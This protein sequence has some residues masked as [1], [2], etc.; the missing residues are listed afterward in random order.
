VITLLNIGL[1]AAGPECQIC[2][3]AILLACGNMGNCGMELIFR[4]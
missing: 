2:L 1:A 3:D 4:I